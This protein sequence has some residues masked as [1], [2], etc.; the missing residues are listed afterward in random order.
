MKA[1][2]LLSVMLVLFCTLLFNENTN[3]QTT[4]VLLGWNDLGMHCSNKDFSKIAVLPPFNNVYSQLI[5]RQVGY[6]P[7]I[8]NVGFKI[9]Y[10]IPNNTTSI[11]KTNFWTYAQELFNLPNPLPPNIGLTGK[12][13][14][15]LMDTVGNGFRVIG[16]PNTPFTDTD[17]VN[18]KPFQIF[19]LS[20]KLI[21]GTNELAFTDNVIP[22]S[23]EIGCVQSGCHSSEQEIK[24]EHP[25]VVGFKQFQPELCARCHASNALGTQGDSIARPFSYRIHEK[26]HDMQPP[27]AIELCYKCHPGP[28]TQCFRDVMRVGISPPLVCQNCHGTMSAIAN[29]I[30]N[31]RRPWLDEPRCGTLT[32]HGNNYS[33]QPGKLYRESKGHGNLYCSACHGSPHAIYPTREVNDNLQSIRL[34]GHS[35]AISNCLVCHSY[36]PP[37]PGPHGIYYI[38]IKKI[39]NEIPEEFELFQN[40]PN[41]FNP[42]TTI[43]FNLPKNGFVKI[44][45]FDTKGKSVKELLSRDLNPGSFEISW[46]ATGLA[47]GV[48]FCKVEYGS[49]NKI[50]KMILIK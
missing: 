11:N 49:F 14:S 8:V 29:S 26:H 42:V 18:E 22:V 28:N 4:Y 1:I 46:D 50:I 9:E 17:L 5:K 34:Q 32:C 44:T 30:D 12:G 39:D 43:K 41:P 40:Y 15:G 33:E 48:Y 31:G 37:G 19:H 45:V 38:G 35:G 36:P 10:S 3:S 23:N 20:A 27:N 2:K 16:I 21:N 25:D 13:L 24:N 6:M 7:Q 47:S